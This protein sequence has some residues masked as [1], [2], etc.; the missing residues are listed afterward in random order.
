[1][2]GGSSGWFGLRR[3]GHV[4][5]PR[6]GVVCGDSSVSQSWLGRPKPVLV[7]LQ[8]IEGLNQEQE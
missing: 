2:L 1:M 7:L 5:A 6:V 4:A 8:L 3:L